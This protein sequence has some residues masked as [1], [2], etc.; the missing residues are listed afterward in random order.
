M[1]CLSSKYLVLFFP[2]LR[3][4]KPVDRGSLEAP[5]CHLC[6]PVTSES[7]AGAHLSPGLSLPCPPPLHVIL[8]LFSESSWIGFPCFL[9]HF[10]S[11]LLLLHHTGRSCKLYLAGPLLSSSFELLLPC[12]SFFL[13]SVHL[14]PRKLQFSQCGGC[15]RLRGDEPILCCRFFL[16]LTL[17]LSSLVT[18]VFLIV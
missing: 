18:F 5:A 12:N 8:S 1:S 14:L 6:S 9:P 16:F 11:H 3:L 15:L 17:I 13:C 10:P 7:L 2:V 4:T